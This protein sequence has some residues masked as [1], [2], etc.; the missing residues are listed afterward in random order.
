VADAGTFPSAEARLSP[1][2][3]ETPLT[4]SCVSLAFCI[5]IYPYTSTVTTVTLEVGRVTTAAAP[6]PSPIGPIARPTAAGRF[7]IRPPRITV[8]SR[9]P[10]PVLE[11]SDLIKGRGRAV[12]VGDG[13]TVQYVEASYAHPGK[14][15]QS[16]WIQGQQGFSVG[17]GEALMAGEDEGVVGMK[18]GGRREL[19]IPPALSLGGTS[20]P[21]ATVVLVVDLLHIS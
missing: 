7:G 1:V 6:W 14:V 4:E 13:V 20:A 17:Q 8:G 19:I 10:P 18:V 16:T 15:I 2:I 3:G 11:E 12:S 9:I 21:I 5:L